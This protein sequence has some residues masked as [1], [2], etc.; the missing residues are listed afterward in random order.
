MIE[1]LDD[2]PIRDF[3]YSHQQ[4]CLYTLADDETEERVKAVNKALHLVRSV[5]NIDERVLGVDENGSAILGIEREEIV[6]ALLE[7]MK[8][9]G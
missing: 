7:E 5:L 4:F 1:I 2:T 3:L 6:A 8:N 9:G